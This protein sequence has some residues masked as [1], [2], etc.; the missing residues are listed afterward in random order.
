M[1]CLKYTDPDGR[2]AYAWLFKP[3]TTLGRARGND[4]VVGLDKSVQQ[5]HAQIAYNGR[6][7]VVSAVDDAALSVDGKRKRRVRLAHDNV[8]T[9]GDGTQLTF[10]A[11]ASPEQALASQGSQACAGDDSLG[12]I[13]QLAELS[14]RIMSEGEVRTQL[15]AILDTAISLTQ[16]DKGFVLLLD[17]DTI[18]VA[19]GRNL[20]RQDVP[21][22]QEALSDSVL[23]KVL[24]T[25]QPLVIDDAVSD[26]M[27][28]SSHSVMSL[29]LSALLCVPLLDQGQV[30][31]L[32]YLGNDRLG[33]TFQP[34]HLEL[35]QA[36]AGH[37]AALLQDHRAV[38]A[39]K[40][41]RDRL[42]TALDARRHGAVIG[43]CATLNH[44]FAAIDKVAATEVSVLVTGE[45]GTGK[46]LIASEIH[47]RSARASG[48]LVTLNCGAIPENLMESELFGHVRGAFTG[49]THTRDGKFQAAHGGTLFLDEVGELPLN[50]QV[51]LLRVLQDKLV[52]RVGETRA[53]PVDIRV[54]A[55]TH[56]DLEA[57]MRDGNF[58]EDLFYRLNV[59]NLQLPPLR[60]RGDDVILLAKYFIKN[61]S[62]E[63]D[64]NVRG[65]SPE[66][67]E[68]VRRYPWPGNV[69]QLE[70][71]LRKAV[72]LADKPLIDL[73]QLDLPAAEGAP[74]ALAEARE[75]FQMRYILEAL[76]R[77]G[78]NRTKTAKEL[79]VDPRTIFRY[80]EKQ[81]HVAETD[82][83]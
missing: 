36:V 2:V 31:G 7:F 79:D 16:A 57:A 33:H 56:R 82:G 51:K 39:L 25:G 9:L 40:A 21:E 55:A 78:G 54:V 5:H 80:L 53:Q 22:E 48:P 18:Q 41:D 38:D 77:N 3:L 46:E 71:K 67:I 42:K 62:K 44:L 11:L 30:L 29:K 43:A 58:R 27:F 73:E 76:E 17:S 1:A 26:S 4:I 81:A 64:R 45:T 8:L 75:A 70:N 19:V 10:L 6:D 23:R 35:V 24:E 52:V 20:A 32:V 50:L 49:A 60:E 13:Q 72:V 34:A 12:G 74:L 14:R 28:A 15:Q 83:A 59:V 63:Y 37:A 61:F 69:R 66:A 47:A 68:A 65:L